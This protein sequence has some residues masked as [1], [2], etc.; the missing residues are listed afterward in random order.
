VLP[1][2]APGGVGIL[3]RGALPE[4]ERNALSDAALMLGGRLESEEPLEGDRRILLV[5]KTGPTAG[6]FPR[7]A[8]VPTKRPLCL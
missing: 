5:R 1:F 4:R 8:G 2:L 3:Q 6:R 7:P